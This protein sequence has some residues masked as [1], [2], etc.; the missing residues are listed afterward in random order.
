MKPLFLAVLLLASTAGAQ[1]QKWEYA[2]LSISRYFKNEAEMRGNIPGKSSYLWLYKTPLLY[3]STD[4]QGNAKIFLEGIFGVP[5]IDM[6][7]AAVLDRLLNVAREP[8]SLLD[9][10]F[11][12][13]Y[14]QDEFGKI[15]WELI[16]V[17]ESC[18]LGCIDAST[19]AV[20]S[21]L[22]YYK[23]ESYWYKRLASK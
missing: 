18:S 6:T 1:V 4:A 16:S 7:P 3:K 22:R 14:M 9:L 15:G 12:L 23:L 8:N 21:G 2:K 13:P 19:E 10:N 11:Q 5:K 20:N 17:S